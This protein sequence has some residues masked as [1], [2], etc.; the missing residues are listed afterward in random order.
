MQFKLM[1]KVI[2]IATIRLLI[3]DQNINLNCKNNLF[4]KSKKKAMYDKQS[5]FNS[6]KARTLCTINCPLKITLDLVK[7]KRILPF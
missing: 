1:F 6:Y 5:F 3:S 7:K 4:T 2:L